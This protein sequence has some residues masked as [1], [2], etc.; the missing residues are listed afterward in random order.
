MKDYALTAECLPR[1]SFALKHGGNFAL[2]LTKRTL[3]AEQRSLI[4]GGSR[5]FILCQLIIPRGTRLREWCA[6]HALSIANESIPELCTERWT[7]QNGGRRT[8]LDY[9]LLDE[10]LGGALQSCVASNA[11][12]TGSDHRAV[13]LR[14]LVGG[15]RARQSRKKAVLIWSCSTNRTSYQKSLDVRLTTPALRS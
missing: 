4:F 5:A 2:S 3:Q 1:Q 11:V 15:S 8:Q 12:D 7:F 6:L 10:Y 14:L 13:D 9:F